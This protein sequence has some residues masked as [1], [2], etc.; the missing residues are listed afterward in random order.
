MRLQQ[1]DIGTYHVHTCR[2]Y[3]ALPVRSIETEY[4]AK[5]FES[6]ESAF[7][8][9]TALRPEHFIDVSPDSERQ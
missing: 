6:S 2:R 5:S 8:E 3:L 1:F 4:V 7:G 9:E